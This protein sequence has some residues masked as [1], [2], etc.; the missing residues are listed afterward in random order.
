[1]KLN[2]ELNEADFKNLYKL[3]TTIIKPY[4]QGKAM[5]ESIYELN[6][7]HCGNDWELSYI[8]EDDSDEPLYCP[9]CGCDVD[10]SDVEDES[11]DDDL[12]FDTDELDF[13]NN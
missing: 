4:L 12:D 8:L 13:E 1:M 7:D 5:P 6:C 3:Y 11:F 9:F 10:L 2:I